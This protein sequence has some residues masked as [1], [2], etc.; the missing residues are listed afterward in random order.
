MK[1][2]LPDSCWLRLHRKLHTPMPSIIEVMLHATVNM[3]SCGL[4][5]GSQTRQQQRPSRHPCRSGTW[6]QAQACRSFLEFQHRV[7]HHRT[8]LFVLQL[9][10]GRRLPN[11]PPARTQTFPFT[12][13]FSSSSKRKHNSNSSQDCDYGRNLVDDEELATGRAIEL[14]E[15]GQRH[16]FSSSQDRAFSGSLLKIR[17]ASLHSIPKH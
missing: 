11:L 17:C 14:E 10:A 2:H 4:R 1:G 12:N 5:Q 7:A 6:L 13:T 8:M 9:G 3:C 16:P 15:W